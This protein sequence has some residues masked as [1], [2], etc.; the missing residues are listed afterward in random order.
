MPP[1]LPEQ[2]QRSETMLLELA[3]AGLSLRQIAAEVA[4]SHET[5]RQRLHGARREPGRSRR[6]GLCL[7]TLGISLHSE[8]DRG[9]PSRLSL[10]R[11]FSAWSNATWSRGS[12]T[13]WSPLS[14]R[15]LGTCAT[16][17]QIHL[18]ARIVHAASAAAA[19]VTRLNEVPDEVP[20]GCRQ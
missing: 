8:I 12:E 1:G 10:I 11:T 4:M 3:V 2:R 7:M 16:N 18:G 6:V 20:G 13:P 14:D 5:V 17:G 19:R 9:L 15:E